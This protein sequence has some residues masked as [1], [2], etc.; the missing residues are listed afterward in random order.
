MA[1]A[2]LEVRI[3]PGSGFRSRLKIY[4]E[5]IHIGDYEESEE[6]NIERKEGEIER[7]ADFLLDTYAKYGKFVVRWNGSDKEIRKYQEG[8]ANPGRPVVPLGVVIPRR[9]WYWA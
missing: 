4:H 6:Q 5:G 3:V 9:Y 8:T 2:E 7:S 1:E